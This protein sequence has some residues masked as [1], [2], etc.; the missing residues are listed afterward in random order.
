M[1]QKIAKAE[2]VVAT[3]QAA[4]ND[5]TIMS[6]AEALRTRYAALEAAQAA[7]DQLYTR[8]AELEEKREESIATQ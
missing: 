3:C 6:D 2:A 5:S 8:W 7:V 4:A 1:E